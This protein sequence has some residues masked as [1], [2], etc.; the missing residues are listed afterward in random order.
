MSKNKTVLEV[1]SR[2]KV[3]NLLISQAVKK[4]F[5]SSFWIFRAIQRYNYVFPNLNVS[6]LLEI[7]SHKQSELFVT[8]ED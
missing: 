8:N 1:D 2:I 5:Q 4:N 3:A 7:I 6:E